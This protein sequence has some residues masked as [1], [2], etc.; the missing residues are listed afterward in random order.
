MMRFWVWPMVLMAAVLLSVRANADN[1]SSARIVAVGD[2]H[3]DYDAW[4]DIARAAR[5]VDSNNH[6]AGSKTVLVQTGDIT[7]RGPD[8]LKIIRHLMQLQREAAKAGGKVVVLIG[9]HEAMQTLGDLRYVDPG[10]YAAFVTRTSDRDRAAT[11]EANKV[12]FEAFYHAK[13]PALSP[14]AIRERWIA[15]TPLGK[16]EHQAAWAPGGAMGR[17]LLTNPAVALIGGNLFVHGGLGPTYAAIPIDEL[18]RRAHA[19]LV[20]QDAT[21]T[22]ILADEAGPLWHRA[23]ANATPSPAIEQELAAVLAATGAKRMVI[24][25]TPILS[26]IAVLYGGRLVRIDTGNS[27]Y[28]KGT[29]SYLEIVGDRPVPHAVARTAGGAK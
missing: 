4:L 10:E 5:L 6:W 16:L 23:Y 20:A 28:Y 12:A 8:S 22:S 3:G 25:H 9:N 15:D 21:P 14:A 29:P 13:D 26:G 24:G 18:N 17:W 7:D 27:R 2:L 1:S 19:A 11:Y